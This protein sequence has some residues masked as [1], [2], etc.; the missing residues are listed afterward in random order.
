MADR[1]CNQFNQVVRI[2]S[3]VL[4][5][6]DPQQGP[7][8]IKLLVNR[9]AIGFEDVQDGGEVA[10][11]LEVPED[12]IREGQPIPLRYVRFQSVNSLHV[13]TTAAVSHSGKHV[14][15]VDLRRIK[16]RRSRPDSHRFCRCTRIRCRVRRPSIVSY[17]ESLAQPCP[18]ARQQI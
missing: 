10:Q 12:T 16:S 1:S 9:P 7:K 5:S 6:A 14:T 11:V 17:S 13:S 18:P 2:R 8:T 3:I 15:F 4:H